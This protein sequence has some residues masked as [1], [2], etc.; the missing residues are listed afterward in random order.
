MARLPNN[1]DR[2]RDGSGYRYIA[3]TR[4]GYAVRLRNEGGV[5]PW[6]AYDFRKG[7]VVHDPR[8]PG[9]YIGRRRTLETVGA[10]VASYVAH[11]E[12]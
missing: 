5:T 2:I 6:A 7:P 11:P 9:H 3:Y 1:V 10:L 8:D 12:A 4:D